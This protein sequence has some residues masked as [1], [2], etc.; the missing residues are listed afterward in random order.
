MNRQEYKE[1]EQDV[2][3]FFKR[4]GITNLTGTYDEETGEG[5]MEPFF[6]WYPCQ[7][8]GSTLGGD[9]EECS[10]W[11]PTTKEVHGPFTVCMDCV[12]YAEYGTLDDQT[13]IEVE[14]E[15]KEVERR[16]KEDMDKEAQM[17]QRRAIEAME[18]KGRIIGIGPFNGGPHSG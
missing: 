5:S 4:E 7:C 14:E 8:C 18:E 9:R 10:G 15:Q 11:N 12:Y 2:A 13:M 17:I 3:D 16:H 6:S 1:Y